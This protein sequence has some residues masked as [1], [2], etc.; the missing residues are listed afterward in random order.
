[1]NC[2]RILVKGIV[3]G[4]GYRAFIYKNA[5]RLPSIKGY[6]KNLFDGSVEI[7]VSGSSSDI[8][9]LIELAKKGPSGALVK[10]INTEQIEISQDFD[11]FTIVY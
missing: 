5:K 2:S 1:M 7:V 11:E 4:V 9:Q 3:Q 8:H 10:E 6:V